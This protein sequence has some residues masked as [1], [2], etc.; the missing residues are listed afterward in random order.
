MRRFLTLFTVMMLTTVL[1]FSQARTVT[2][3]VKDDS[4]AP[5]PFATVTETGSRNATTADE[6]GNFTIQM[7]KAG[8]L[9]FSA[10]GYTTGAM[11][12]SGDKLNATIARS[13]AELSAVVVT[14]AG[15]KRQEKTIGYAISQVDPSTLLQKSE[16]DILKGLQGKVAGVDIRTG[17]G[18]PGAASRIQIRGNSSF[19]G[20]NQPLIIVDGVPYSN[21][22]VSTSGAL[23]GGGAYGSGLADLDPNDIASM[24]ILKGSSAG[25]LYG[26]RA[27]NGVIIITTKSGSASRTKKGTEINFRSSVSFE[28]IS[29]L[30][31][32]QNAFGTGS[33][34]NASNANGSWGK[35]FAPGDSL[36]VWTSI[37]KAYPEL[38]PSGKVPYKAYPN[39]VA[40]QFQTGLVTENSVGFNT[41]DEKTSFALTASQVNHSGYVPNN[42]YDRTNLSAG[43]SSKLAIGLNISGNFSY[44]RSKQDGGLFGENQVGSTSSQFGRTM[45]LGRSWDPNVPFEDKNGNSISWVGDQA[46][47]PKW[48]AKYNRQTTYDERF[49]AGFHADF[50]INKWARVDYNIGNNVFYLNRTEVQEVSSRN[51]PGRLAID[52]YRRQELESTLLLSLTP[53]ISEDFSL[54]TT[55]GTSYNQRSTNDEL[56]RGGYKDGSSGYIARGLY[57]LNN[58]VDKDREIFN[59]YSRRR[60]FGVFGELT[61]GFKNYA[62][63]TVTGRND[64]SSTLPANNRSYFYPSV[65]GSFI[66]SD[67]LKLKGGILD[68]GKLRAGYAKVG[69]DADPYNQFNVY[70]LGTTFLGQTP[71]YINPSA[72]S[73]GELQPEFTKELELGTQLSFF[74]KHLELDFTY[75]DKNSS[76]LLA[77]VVVPASTGYNNLYTNFGSI[78]NKGV[79]IELTVRPIMG[80]DFTWEI[81]SVFTQNKNIVTSLRDGMTSLNLGGGTTDATTQ[82]IAGKP[83]GSLWGTKD[84]RDS[85]T[86]QLLIDPSTGSMIEDPTQQII[87]DPNPIFKLGITNTFRYKGFFLSALFDMTDGGSLYSVTVSSLLGRGVTLDTRDRSAGWIIPGIY[88]DAVTGKAITD[89]GKTIPNQGRISTNDLYFSPPGGNTFAIN[90]ASEWNVYDATVYRLRELTLGFDLPKSLFKNVPIKSATF[91]VTGRNLWYLAPGF[92]KHTNFD[93]ETSSF[94]SS[95]IQGLEFSAAPT[96][97]RFGLNLN[98][99]F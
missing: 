2:G 6:K 51:T 60:L 23:T 55:L 73:G 67:A 86:G 87:G 41:G 74:K 35:A 15:I 16:P 44:S 12:V 26:S 8:S 42:K 32:Y 77:G 58:F 97:K 80:K 95:S 81:R 63:V 24:N 83:W 92:P 75:Y 98:V 68:Y 88:G 21:P 93:P 48:A 66:F 1:A 89:G 30:P 11:K 29:N 47:N 56:G 19:F 96:T 90:T 33:L 3:T 69:R 62:F 10:A 99:T 25:A 39:N 70:V 50:N 72:S 52:N 36:G 9:T 49:V 38:Y 14:A 46:D 13:A 57:T 5:V 82:F 40:D 84:L 27:S 61:L 85:A 71:G 94:G 64:I 31:D 34:G 78:S 76:N 65:S 20:D 79:E 17:Q 4:G 43:G 59:T 53:N 54:K 37:G 28:Q 22:S 18:T 7:K 91:S 45:F